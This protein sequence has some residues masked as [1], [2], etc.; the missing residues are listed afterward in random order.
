[1]GGFDAVSDSL[2]TYVHAI[3]S[4]NQGKTVIGATTTASGRNLILD[5]NLARTYIIR[6]QDPA[7]Q[8]YLINLVKALEN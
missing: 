3:A 5:A 8:I 6:K 2:S 1:M 7:I 4:D